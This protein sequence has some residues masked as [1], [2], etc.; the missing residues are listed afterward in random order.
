MVTLGYN[1]YGSLH[2]VINIWLHF[3]TNLFYHY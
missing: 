1:E 3:M 2:D